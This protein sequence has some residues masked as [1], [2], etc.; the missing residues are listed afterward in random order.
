[1]RHTLALGCAEHVQ[2]DPVELCCVQNDLYILVDRERAA[3]SIHIASFPKAVIVADTPLLC[4]EA[5]GQRALPVREWSAPVIEE[6]QCCCSLQHL[7]YN[8]KPV[9]TDKHQHTPTSDYNSIT[10]SIRTY[11]KKALRDATVDYKAIT[12]LPARAKDIGQPHSHIHSK[13]S[14]RI[15]PRNNS[16]RS[17]RPHTLSINP[18]L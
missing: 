13:P 14:C 9:P 1:M 12:T 7:R 11:R 18:L 17:P 3:S 15:S 16:S 10:I 4:P 5:E 8:A 2:D 6:N